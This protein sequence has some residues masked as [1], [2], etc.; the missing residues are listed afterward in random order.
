MS[1][2]K[3]KPNKML[4]FSKNFLEK[5]NFLKKFKTKIIYYIVNHIIFFSKSQIKLFYYLIKK[6]IDKLQE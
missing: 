5:N 1:K 3:E 4:D 6:I 2:Q